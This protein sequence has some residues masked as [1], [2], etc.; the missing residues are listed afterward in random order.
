MLSISVAMAV[1]NG[2]AY[3]SEQIDSIL[4]Q[5]GE[6]DELVI[7]YNKSID[8]TLKIIVDYQKKDNRVKVFICDTKG[9]LSNFENAIRHC[10]NDIIYLSDQDDVWI[11][12]K[13]ENTISYF[14]NKNI[15]AIVHD[16][17]YVDKNLKPLKNNIECNNTPKLKKI[18]VFNIIYKNK[19]QGSCLAF[20][21]QLVDD[22]L[23][24]PK[25]I[26]M[27]DSWI[28]L[29]SN[30]YGDVII[31]NKPLLYYRIHGDNVS[32]VKHKAFSG[33]LRD[34]VSLIKNYFIIKRSVRYR[35]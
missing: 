28:G 13:I 3:L 26:P 21:K 12:G 25:D 32:P 24:F 20:R 1:Y 18:K 10:K 33:M 22:I 19:V 2:E 9:V 7:S 6:K 23:P 8:N 16:K 30:I 17:I 27:H 11:K 31:V 15:Y 34:R 4:E 29:I 14:E 5:L 35:K